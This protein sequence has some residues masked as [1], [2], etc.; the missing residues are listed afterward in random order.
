V[1][2][3]FDSNILSTD[4]NYLALRDNPKFSEYRNYCENLWKR[5]APYADPD[6]PL[7]F[8]KQLQPR[9]WELYLGCSLLDLGFSIIP[10]SSSKGPDFHIVLDGRNIWIEAIAPNNGEGP[11]AVP[12][13]YE[14]SGFDPMPE[15]KIILRF[16][17]AITEKKKKLDAYIRSGIVSSNDIFVIALN[18]GGINMLMFDGPMPTV[19]K[20]VYP[21]GDE[22]VTVD[23]VSRKVI[24]DKYKLRFEIIKDSRKAV[25]TRAFINPEYI[26]ITGI[27]YSN[28]SLGT[29]PSKLGDDFL[30]I[31]NSIA[32]S[33][34]KYGWLRTGKECYKEENQLLVMV[35]R[36]SD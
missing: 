6:F 24:S 26:N 8:S 4:K 25:S 13:I 36:T 17:N 5:F 18:G 15:D 11:D 7:E 29:L 19:I 21:V 2:N 35:N 22:V 33:K 27:L 23:V 16:T 12:D 9:F 28:V 3:I 1:K 20:S 30:F 32:I 31:H 10:K 14:H 34:L